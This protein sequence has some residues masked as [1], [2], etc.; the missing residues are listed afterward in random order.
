MGRM[1]QKIPMPDSK[2]EW[3]DEIVSAYLDAKDA[4]PFSVLVG[5]E[6]TEKELFHLAPLVCLKFRGIKNTDKNRNRATD[7]ALS[8]YVA[9]EESNNGILKD[10]IMAFGFCYI[11]SHYGLDLL[12][13]SEGEAILQYIENNLDEMKEKVET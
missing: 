9:N 5:S 3:L 10:P 8:S 11:L 4:L 12:S 7:A 1:R 2:S 13:E 6:I